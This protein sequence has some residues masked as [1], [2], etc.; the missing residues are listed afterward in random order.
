MRRLRALIKKEFIHIRRDPRTLAL[1]FLLPIMQ[2]LLLGYAINND[3]KNIPVV[4]YDQD[5]SQA[6]RSLLEAFKA[7]N[8]FRFDY[9]AFSQQEV[10]ELIDSGKAQA[11]I[12]IPPN[13]SSELAANRN[14]EVAILIDGSDPSIAGTA[15]S[16]AILISQSYSTEIR[17]ERMAA[18]GMGTSLVASIDARPRVLYNPNLQ[19]SFNMI[20]GLIGII[21]M[22][23]TIMLTSFAIVRE[24]EQGT[25]EQ[26]IVTPIRNIELMVAKIIPYI[27]IAFLDIIMVML[28]GTFL[29]K[30]PIRGSVPLLLALAALFII[31]NL[32]IGLL[33][34]TFARSQMEAMF[35]AMPIILPSMFLSGFLFPL[36][37]MPVI[38]Q[39]ISRVIPLT[40]F[41]VITRGIIVKGIGFSLLIP[42][43]IA[44]TIFA[45]L[46]VI[47]AATRFKKTIE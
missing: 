17:L 11:G 14:A 24:R 36:A 19:N 38:L 39:W 35:T 3:V 22:M 7:S 30:V 41:L 46:M 29:F 25:I 8:Y 9:I 44:L 26:L 20:P 13:Y 5:N 28:V 37:S 4:I 10:L 2:L 31:P 15:L 43:T 34:S 16:N 21:M 47:L 6:S 27:L 1:M 32:G 40:Y 45:V 18:I 33:V 23:I 42:Q 12:I